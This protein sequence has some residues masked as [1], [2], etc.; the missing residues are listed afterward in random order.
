MPERLTEEQISDIL[1][2]WLKREQDDSDVP[3]L[4][5]EIVSLQK[6]VA[7]G[8]QQISGLLEEMQNERGM[9]CSKG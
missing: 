1:M 8:N 3:T 2:R 5:R 7:N 4:L 6:A 9:K